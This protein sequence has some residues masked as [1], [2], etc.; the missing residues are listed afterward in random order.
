MRSDCF[1]PKTDFG[2]ARIIQ[3]FWR[4]FKE[5]EP[6]NARLAWLS[7]P[8]DNIPEDKK[9]LGLTSHEVKNSQTREQFNQWRT[10]WIE[11]Y[12]NNPMLC[13]SIINRQYKEYYIPDN[14]IDSKKSQL[15]NR[16]QKRLLEIE[17]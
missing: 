5:K 2:Y 10:K 15:R 17:A 6:S 14:W 12:K 9:F 8:N 4:S 7:L 13:S 1:R 11:F 16:F 3:K